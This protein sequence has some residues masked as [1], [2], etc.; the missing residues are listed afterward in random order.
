MKGTASVVINSLGLF[1]G[2]ALVLLAAF[3]GTIQRTIQQRFRKQTL[4]FSLYLSLT[5][6]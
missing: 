2:P 1:A 6:I 5:Q 3:C 4:E